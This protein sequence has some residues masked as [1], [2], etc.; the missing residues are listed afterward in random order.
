MH[1]KYTRLD[2]FINR[3][4]G[5]NRRDVRLM[6]AQGRVVVDG[7]IARDINQVVG[8]FSHVV[9]DGENL[10]QRSPVYI[11]MNKPEGVVSATK[12][13]I[14]T[15][16]I[17]LLDRPDSYQL[18]IAGRLD[19]NTTGLMLLTNDGRWSRQL[20]EPE[21][22]V[23][24]WYRVTLQYPMDESYE[25]AFMQ[26]MHFPYENITTLPAVLNKLSDTVAEV[27]LMEGRYHQVK[28][29]FGRLQN[30]VVELHRYAVGD[31][32]L[33]STLKPGQS[34]ELSE[35]ELAGLLPHYSHEA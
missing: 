25:A 28:R 4:V 14:H 29:M 22:K 11:M 27:G 2:R 19:F 33:D 8:E 23:T 20:F 34:R 18:H 6:L 12:D 32:Q 35:Q 30:K 26:G 24:K 31:L 17:D 16:V 10:Q 5:V 3:H 15:T 1:S 21:S 13:D 9:A 7:V